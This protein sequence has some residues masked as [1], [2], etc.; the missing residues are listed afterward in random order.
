MFLSGGDG[1]DLLIGGPGPDTLLGGAG[2][3]T[4]NAGLGNDLIDGGAG[5]DTAVFSSPFAAYSFDTDGTVIHANGPDGIDTLLNVELFQFSD[6]LVNVNGLNAVFHNTIQGTSSA[7]LLIGTGDRDWI[8]GDAG[9]DTLDG[10]GGNDTLFGGAGADLLI[11]GAGEDLL[12][13][14]PG[15]DVLNGG[16]GNDTLYGGVGNDIFSFLAGSGLDIVADFN[17]AEGD[18]IAIQNNINGSGITTPAAASAMQISDGANSF[19]YL[20]KSA[21]LDQWVLIASTPHLNVSDFLITS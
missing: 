15:N 4:L 12:S 20:G 21:G 3:D 16:A 11:G 19:V 14:G 9:N 1:R 8:I 18:K 13:G 5:V 10:Q 6:R 17:S 7:D 2:D